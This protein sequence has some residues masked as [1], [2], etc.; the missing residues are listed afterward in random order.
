MPIS[1]IKALKE[2][3][4]KF[5]I[6]SGMSKNSLAKT[7]EISQSQVSN[8]SNFGAKRWTKNTKKV[9]DF[10]EEYYQDNIKIPSK[11]EQKIKRIL[12]NNPQNKTHILSALEIINSLTKDIK[13][14]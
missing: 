14:D 7:L 12:T 3:L 2:R 11:I 5:L 8:L 4:N 6:D 9:N 1:A 13:D 10:I